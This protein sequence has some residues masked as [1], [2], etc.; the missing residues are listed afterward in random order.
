LRAVLAAGP[1]VPGPDD[2]IREDCLVRVGR[3]GH[4]SHRGYVEY[5]VRPGGRRE[6]VHVDTYCRITSG[7]G[8]MRCRGL[9]P[10]PGTDPA[11]ATCENCGGE[12]GGV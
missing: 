1:V 12:G 5:R 9:T 6:V 8:R 7:T 11:R 3:Q 2:V 4:R 10:F